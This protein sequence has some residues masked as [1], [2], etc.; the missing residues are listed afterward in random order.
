MRVWR[1]GLGS[2]GT[3]LTRPWGLGRGIHAA[4]TPATPTRP[5]SDSLLARPVDPRHAR[6]K[7][8]HERMFLN[9]CF[10]R[11]EPCSAP[12]KRSEA[13]RFPLFLLPPW[14]AARRNLSEAGRVGR[15]GA[16][17]PWMAPSSLQGRTCSVPCTAH[18]PRHLHEPLSVTNQPPLSHEGLSRWPN[19]VKSPT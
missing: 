3:P 4:D 14:P 16:L 5:T 18:P 12:S 2:R 10:C 9:E 7:R 6:M 15:A 13:T 17:A 8:S 11:A 19:P 1:G